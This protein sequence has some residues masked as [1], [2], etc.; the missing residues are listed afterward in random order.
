MATEVGNTLKPSGV[1]GSGLY[2]VD[3]ASVKEYKASE[4]LIRDDDKETLR[5]S[6]QG[7][8]FSR[9]EFSCWEDVLIYRAGHRKVE[10]QPL[11]IK[12]NS[13]DRGKRRSY[14]FQSSVH[15]LN[16]NYIGLSLILTTRCW[17]PNIY[18]SGTQIFSVFFENE[19]TQNH[20][21]WSF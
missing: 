19:R 6:I 14:V 5:L 13:S 3:S 20:T 16:T 11:Y 15:D 17:S 12:Y 9:R 4:S 2:G 10:I 18:I 7:F 1:S 8:N 21:Y